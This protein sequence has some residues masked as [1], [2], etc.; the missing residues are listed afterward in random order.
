MGRAETVSTRPASLGTVRVDGPSA[1]VTTNDGERA[2]PEPLR[3]FNAWYVCLARKNLAA[4]AQTPQQWG[5]DGGV[6][7]PDHGRVLHLAA[8]L[9]VPLRSG[10]AHV[11]QLRPV[12]IEDIFYQ[13]APKRRYRNAHQQALVAWTRHRTWPLPEWSIHNVSPSVANFD[14]FDGRRNETLQRITKN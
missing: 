1:T 9:G 6:D 13:R 2:V 14:K 4:H 11:V 10:T 3:H 12:G 7:Q 8:V 5:S